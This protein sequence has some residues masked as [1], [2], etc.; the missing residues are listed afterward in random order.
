MAVSYRP[1]DV[2]IH[3]MRLWSMDRSR[4]IENLG[5]LVKNIKIYESILDPVMSA[6]FTVLD[7]I[8]L[9][10]TFPLLGEEYIE[11]DIET[12][13]MDEIFSYRFDVIDISPINSSFGDKGSV[14]NLMCVSQ[15]FRKNTKVL[16]DLYNEAT[17]VDI[18]KKILKGPLASDKEFNTADATFAKVDLDL[19][20]LRPFEAIDKIRLLTRNIKEQSSAFCFFENKYGFNFLSVEQMFSSGKT[21]IGDKIFFFDE[22]GGNNIEENDF[23]NIVGLTKLAEFSPV[24][25]TSKGQLNAKM[26]TFDIIT[27]E[28]TEKH[29]KDSESSSGF[30]YADDDDS[31]LRSSSGQVDDGEE[32]AQYLMNVTDSSKSDANI[33]EMSLERASYVNK[34]IQQLFKMEIYGDFAMSVGDVV[35]VELPSS[36]SMTD[37]SDINTD[38]RYAGNFLVS[39]LV[40]NINMANPTAKHSTT[41]EIIKGN[42]KA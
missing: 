35:E 12:P 14:Y 10:E 28:V 34:I 39:R 23:R 13:G 22:A 37:R 42:L 11:L 8:G 1:G 16:H 4:S 24:K 20:Q 40:H 25:A 29:Y 5:G 21:K 32:P 19:T 17:S 18:I 36:T 6:V 41:C 9:A 3:G 31:P 26:K 38:P 15:E 33:Q 2:K 7:T 27:G 30:V